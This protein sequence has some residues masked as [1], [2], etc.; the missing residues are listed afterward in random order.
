MIGEAEP[1]VVL[2]GG[3][4]GNLTSKLD[5]VGIAPGY[6]Q[7]FY[8]QSGGGESDRYPVDL[9]R[10][11]EATAWFSLENNVEDLEENRRKLGA[12]K[13]IVLGHSWGGALA[14]FYA[15]AHPDRVEKLVIYN[16]GPMWP[17]LRS[18]KKAFFK[19]R[20]G[21]ELGARMAELSAGINENLETW[22][23]MAATSRIHPS[24][25][26]TCVMRYP[27]TR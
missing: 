24:A 12:Q 7:V 5:L 14:A 15:A 19:A 20:L 6:Q 26:L 3:P 23:Q 10:L 21:P 18:A 17:E 16:G 8:D 22:D 4:G 1:I 11:E 27:T 25:R 2:H 9:E 13:I